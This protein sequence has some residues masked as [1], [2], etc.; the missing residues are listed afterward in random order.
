[1]RTLL[2]RLHASRRR[3]WWTSFGL[4]FALSLVWTFTTPP[5]GAGDE[6]AH[7]V[8]AHAL[9]D[10]D[11]TGASK[12]GEPEYARY[13]QSPAAYVAVGRAALCYVFEPRASA[14]CARFRGSDIE[15][16]T[17]TDAGRHPPAYYAVIGVPTKLFSPLP[18]ID[19]MRVISAAICAALL[20][21]AVASLQRL[22]GRALAAAGLALAVTPTLLY[23]LGIVN[24]NAPE[25]AAAIALWASGM[26]LV[27]RP[28]WDGD[29]GATFD[30]RVIARVGV[31][32]TVLVLTRQTAPFWFAAIALALV[33]L[34]SR[35]ILRRLTRERSAR[36][37]G[38]ILLAAL[39]FQAAWVLIVRPL[40]V[41][42]PQ[43][44]VQ[45]GLGVA[46]QE[47]IGQIY[48]NYV[49]M[50]GALGFMN[51]PVP[52]GVLVLW[53]AAIGVLVAFAW[54]FAS[55]RFAWV[56][57]GLIAFVLVVPTALEAA[58]AQ[59][60]GLYWQGRYTLP[61]AVGIPLVAA[62]GLAVTE[63]PLER[64]GRLVPLLGGV[65]LVGQVVSYAQQLRRWT[66][67]SRGTLLFFVDWDW[68]RI[69]P[70]WLL[71]VAFVVLATAL[72]I[73][74]C[75]PVRTESERPGESNGVAP[76]GRTPAVAAS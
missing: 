43:F 24:P 71:L 23:M 39:V 4:F 20:A 33:A 18:R 16:S 2:E 66:V 51:E 47:S 76:D 10:G 30:P 55:R 44:A 40:D 53:T 63:R 67:G 26:I 49:E 74:L 5:L 59:E 35:D 70:P 72:T 54:V 15:V 8:R 14:A 62:F 56:V 73:W 64:F 52:E 31:A 65:F 32:A 38:A 34:S 6:T 41:S 19:A 7:V 45:G 69:T 1:V 28:M 9:A 57:G 3:V 42:Y 25:V 37:W 46:I 60:A 27:A 58:R 12:R 36:L 75:A 50:I 17:R 13:V 11:L 61:V 21:S 48:P 68:S 29:P 22:R